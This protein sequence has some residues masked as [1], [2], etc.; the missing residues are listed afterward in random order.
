MRKHLLS[1][2]GLLVV[3][4]AVFHNV[5][6]PP[7][8]VVA[9]DSPYHQIVRKAQIAAK[10]SGVMWSEDGYLGNGHTANYEVYSPIR[11]FVPP[12]FYN[13]VVFSLCAFLAALGFYFFLLETGLSALPAFVGALS[14]LFSG[15][16]ITCVFSGHAGTFMMWAAFMFD[17]FAVAKALNKRSVVAMVWSGVLSAL[18]LRY[19]FDIGFIMLIVL[20]CFGLFLLWKTWDKKAFGKL[21]LGFALAA[22]VFIAFGSH[23][24]FYVLGISKSAKGAEVQTVTET[25]LQKWD[26]ATQWSLP[27]TET[28]S[29]VFP[30]IMGWSNQD[31]TGPYY[32][33]IGQ[34]LS[35]PKGGMENFSLNTQAEGAVV[36]LLSLLAIA[37]LFFEKEKGLTIFWTIVALIGLLLSY[38][39]YCDVSPGSASGFGPYRIFYHLPMMSDMRNPIKFLY[40]VMLALSFLSALGFSKLCREGSN[41]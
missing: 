41:A 29:L 11:R 13:T 9:N 36:I 5:L 30:G 27:I 25:P 39:R 16:Y 4:A 10:P 3:T 22:M 1:I 31:E 19:Q 40:P 33:R 37:S 2:L 15:H 38:G 6:L 21:F 28:G 17:L 23:A 14:L 20:F 24:F 35:W 26:W 7:K 32:G 8:P 12:T 18:V 34:S